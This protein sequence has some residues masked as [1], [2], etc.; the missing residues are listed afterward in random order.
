MTPTCPRSSTR[1]T[2]IPTRP[3]HAAA[4]DAVLHPRDGRLGP[5]PRRRR[6]RLRVPGLRGRHE[7]AFEKNLPFALDV[8]KSAD[9]PGQSG[10]AP[11]PDRAA[12]ES[13]PFTTS[14][15]DPQTV[16]STS[17]ARSARSRSTGLSTPARSTRAASQYNGGERYGGVLNVY[18]HGV[19]GAV[20]GTM[21]GDDVRSGSR[22]AVSARESFGY[23]VHSDTGNKVLI[24]AAED[25]SGKPGAP[26]YASAAAAD[27]VDY[28]KAALAANEIA[29]DVYDV[30]AQRPH[31]ARPAGRALALQRGRLVHRQRPLR[32]RAAAC[33]GAPV[34]AE[35][36]QRR[37]PRVRDYL[38]DGGKLLYTGQNAAFGQVGP[39][40]RYN[41]AGRS[42]R[43]A[44]ASTPRPERDRTACR[45]PQRLPAV[46]AGG[47][48]PHRRRGTEAD[49]SRCRCAWTVAAVRHA[50]FRAQRRRL[51]R[52][53]GAPVL[54]GDDLEHPAAGRLSRS[55]HRLGGQVRPPAGLRPAD[56]HPLRVSRSD[57]SLPAAAPDDR[58]HRQDDRALTFKVSYDTE[59]TT[60]TCSSRPTPSARTTG[61]RCP[62]R[63][64]TP[65]DGGGSCDINWDTLHP[66]LAHYQTNTARARRGRGLH[67]HG[68]D[69]RVERRHRQLR[70]LPGLGDRP[71]RLR[72]QAGRGRRSPT[73]RTRRQGLGVF[74]DD[75]GSPGRRAV[76]RRRRSRTA[77]AAGPPA[78]RAGIGDNATLERTE[79]VGF[80]D[81]PG[82]ATR[83]LALLGLRPRGRHRR[84][85]RDALIGDAMGPRHRC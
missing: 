52:Q 49:A 38:N 34:R 25:Y 46:L 41:P 79:S 17:S 29:Y 26:A 65:R 19:R 82:I 32:P 8:A 83:R 71:E 36:R 35:A 68:H 11:R 2:A 59:P 56:G 22:P 72:G 77:S 31:R 6:L 63:T 64:G 16:R 7:Q 57:A 85:Q 58:P 4:P 12:F 13:H 40:S 28:Y 84:D 66:F 37:D 5:G 62:T 1:P 61:R 43:T 60:T 20:T 69:R 14:Y 80:I 47:L 42:R 21:P 78:H 73:R 30:D 55:S 3:A 33:R 27:F 53:P 9:G 50:G 18:Y 15:G 44:S 45:C 48:R 67:D 81:G 39:R 75:V 23:H 51:G 54:V 24:M 10:L 76:E 70:R 74:L